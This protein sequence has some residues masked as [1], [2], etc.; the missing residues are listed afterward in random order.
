M[1]KKS[2]DSKIKLFKNSFDNCYKKSGFRPRDHDRYSR[3]KLPID[4]EVSLLFELNFFYFTIFHIVKFYDSCYFT[5]LHFAWSPRNRVSLFTLLRE[6]GIE[7]FR[8]SMMGNNLV[9]YSMEE[10]SS[11]SYIYQPQICH[12]TYAISCSQGHVRLEFYLPRYLTYITNK[13]ICIAS[14]WRTMF[15]REWNHAELVISRFTEWALDF[16]IV[17]SW[18]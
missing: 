4:V 6:N 18:F 17:H 3:E 16:K 2:S 8:I 12:V 10:S 1:K 5:W 15:S 9:A 14:T 11:F 7:C 13:F